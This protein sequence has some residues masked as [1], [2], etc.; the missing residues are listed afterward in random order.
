M[1]LRGFTAP[2][3]VPNFRRRRAASLKFKILDNPGLP[4]YSVS[5]NGLLEE[6]VSTNRKGDGY[7]DRKSRLIERYTCKMRWLITMRAVRETN[8]SLLGYY[9]H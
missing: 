7:S 1:R 9:S 4:M 6:Y 8:L 5:S 3:Y 2:G